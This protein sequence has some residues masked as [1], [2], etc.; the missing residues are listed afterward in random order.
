MAFSAVILCANRSSV[1]KFVLTWKFLQI[2]WMN[3]DKDKEEH[4]S[5]LSC[6]KSGRHCNAA[7]SAQTAHEFC[8]ALCSLEVFRTDYRK[9]EMLGQRSVC[10]RKGSVHV[11]V[12]QGVLY[13]YWYS[14]GFCTCAGIPRGSIFFPSLKAF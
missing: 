1:S 8:D 4:V 13:M 12:F 9:Q 11:L 7:A 14:K 2:Y 5:Q 10:E 3:N 6:E